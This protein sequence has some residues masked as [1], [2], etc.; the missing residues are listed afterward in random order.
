M[1]KQQKPSRNNFSC[2]TPTKTEKSTQKAQA[3]LPKWDNKVRCYCP[4]MSKVSL[5]P[6]KQVAQK[7]VSVAT[8]LC[9]VPAVGM[10]A[11]V[12]PQTLADAYAQSALV[13]LLDQQDETAADAGQGGES[14]TGATATSATQTSVENGG[15]LTLP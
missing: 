11:G 1:N 7:F 4:K 12:Q 6:L 10:P 15:V 2:T 14:D 13:Q 9:M 8:A 5:A 3:K